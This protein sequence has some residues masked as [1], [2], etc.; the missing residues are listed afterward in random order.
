MPGRLDR[1]LAEGI[2]RR[3]VKFSPAAAGWGFAGNLNFRALRQIDVSRERFDSVLM[4]RSIE[5]AETAAVAAGESHCRVGRNTELGVWLSAG[6]GRLYG[7]D[8]S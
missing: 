1:I 7:Q 4:V 2:A 6:G 5:G 8:R 3:G